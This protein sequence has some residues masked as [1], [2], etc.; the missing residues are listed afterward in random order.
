MLGIYF[1]IGKRRNKPK[2]LKVYTETDKR[3][4]SDVPLIAPY[5]LPHISRRRLKAVKHYTLP[6]SECNCCGSERVDLVNN[7]EIYNGKEYGK[8]PYAYLCR[9]CGAYV[10]LH[11]HTDLPLGTLASKQVRGARKR[12]KDVFYHQIQ[13]KMFKGDRTKAYAW[14][15]NQANIREEECHFGM[16]DLETCHTIE[17]LFERSNLV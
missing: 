2:P 16:F 4:F 3:A 9:D 13:C 6:P 1:S 17:E 11:P 12:I 7:S 5:P 8:W 15:S 10:G 14:L